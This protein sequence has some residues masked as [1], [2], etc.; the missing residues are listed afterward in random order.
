MTVYDDE[1]AHLVEMLLVELIEPMTSPPQ[2]ESDG[3]GA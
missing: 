3:N 2:S 1:G